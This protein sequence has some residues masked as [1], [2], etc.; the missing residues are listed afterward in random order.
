MK[1]VWKI[2]VVYM[3]TLSFV[4]LANSAFSQVEAVHF[5][6]DWN[7]ANGVEWFNKLSDV[8]KDEIDIMVGDNQKKYQIA[9]I[10]TIIIFDDGEEVKRFQADLSFKMVATKEEVQGY[11]DE[12]IMSKF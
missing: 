9:I 6:A 1:P 4:L 10:P 2:F 3:L 8:E 12:L 7:E 5:N 11:I